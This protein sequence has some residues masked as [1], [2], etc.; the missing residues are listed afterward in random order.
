MAKKD[1][2]VTYAYRWTYLP[3]G[4]TGVENWEGPNRKAFLAD[5]DKWNRSLPNHWRFEEIIEERLMQVTIERTQV[6]SLTVDVR[7]STPEEAEKYALDQ[8]AM[9][10]NFD[11]GRVVRTEYKA[12]AL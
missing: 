8:T 2:T 11:A 6:T 3:T 7:A 10:Y 12:K 4:G 5:L 1:W 9:K